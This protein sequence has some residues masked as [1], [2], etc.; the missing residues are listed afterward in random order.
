[1]NE[2]KQENLNSTK[3]DIPPEMEGQVA[4]TTIEPSEPAWSAADTRSSDD[5]IFRLKARLGGEK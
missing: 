4:I 3:F 5:E 2:M 1:M